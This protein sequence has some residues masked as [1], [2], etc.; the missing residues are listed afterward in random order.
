LPLDVVS[1]ADPLLVNEHEALLLAGP[2]SVLALVVVTF[3]ATARRGT[4]IS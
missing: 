3:G 1:L 4:V 2:Q